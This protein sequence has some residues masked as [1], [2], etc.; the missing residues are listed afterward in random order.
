MFTV[1][2]QMS[3]KETDICRGRTKFRK[4]AHRACL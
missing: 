4:I 2:L 3:V 1:E